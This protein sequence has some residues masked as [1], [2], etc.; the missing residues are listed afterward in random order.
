MGKLRARRRNG[1][2]LIELLVTIAIIGTLAMMTLPAVQKAREAANRA[3]CENTNR[4]LGIGLHVFHDS[5]HFFPTELGDATYPLDGQ[6]FYQQIASMVEQ[7][8]AQPGQQ[9]KVFL[10]PSR[11]TRDGGWADFGYAPGTGTAIL[12]N[13][14]AGATLIAISNANGASNTAV[15]AHLACGTAD[16]ANGP[17]QW[18]ATNCGLGGTGQSQPDSQ[19]ATGTGLSSPHANTN[20]VLFADAHISRIANQWMTSGQGGSAMWDWTNATAIEFP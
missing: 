11:G 7:Q 5:H 2:T 12:A 9:V 1:F 16:Y 10:C 14:Q 19:A 15:L 4:Q 20:V 18:G 6:G 8:S 17:I 13:P 3:S